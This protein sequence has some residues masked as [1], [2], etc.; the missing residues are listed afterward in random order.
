M[1]VKSFIRI[2]I[3]SYSLSSI[4]EDNLSPYIISTVSNMLAL[5]YAADEGLRKIEPDLQKY[6]DKCAG[7]VKSFLQRKVILDENF[8]TSM[9]LFVIAITPDLPPTEDLPNLNKIMD[10]EK[11]SEVMTLSILGKES[12]P[13]DLEI[14]EE[15]LETIL[16]IPGYKKVLDFIGANPDIVLKI[17]RDKKQKIDDIADILTKAAISST[18][19]MSV[20]SGFA[21][22]AGLVT[23]SMMAVVGNIIAVSSFTAIAAAVI[24]PVSIVALKYG[25][26][27][28]E[29]IGSK[30][31]QFEKS[32]KIANIERH[33][34]L[35]SISPNM[36]Y[37]NLQAMNLQKNKNIVPEIEMSKI[38]LKDITKDLS[39]HV[40]FFLK[41]QNVAKDNK[42]IKD[43]L[44]KSNERKI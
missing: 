1:L 20:T 40:D 14:L 18:K 27:L 35:S 37:E 17:L 26:E 23:C 28:G 19:A 34:V 8:N 44:V 2:D 39:A 41:D 31:A 12:D 21:Q 32:F 42:I 4:L 16:E 5:Y 6:S 33:M 29:A 25:A 22:L 38:N 9:S 3:F 7:R 11:L 24:I 43:S 10:Q 36:E 30:L 13:Q 15:V